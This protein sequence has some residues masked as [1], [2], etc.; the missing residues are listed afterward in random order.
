MADLE[1]QLNRKGKE[2]SAK[3]REFDNH[4]QQV[5]AIE[6]KLIKTRRQMIDI[7]ARNRKLQSDIQQKN[8]S[9]ETFERRVQDKKKEWETRQEIFEQARKTFD[10]K[11]NICNRFIRLKDNLVKK[12]DQHRQVQNKIDTDLKHSQK[13]FTLQRT[14]IQHVAIDLRQTEMNIRNPTY[15]KSIETI[16]ENLEQNEDELEDLLNEQQVLLNKGQFHI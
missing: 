5:E 14:N 4:Q 12:I 8:Q 3:K 11:Q 6:G 10:E 15:Q 1:V 9:K 16:D 13:E 2:L 7:D